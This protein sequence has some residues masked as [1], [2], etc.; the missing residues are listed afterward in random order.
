MTRV[1]VQPDGITY[2]ANIGE[3]LM[4]AA[5][6]RGLYWPTTCGGQG[7]CTTC[8]SEVVS[9]GEALNDMGR[10]E[11]KTLVNER[12]EA[13]LKR[14]VRLAC[15]QISERHPFLPLRPLRPRVSLSFPSGSVARLLRSL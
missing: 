15:R 10:S 14:P 11:R 12:G 7:V 5:Q 13:V 9:G 1:T 6:A 8:L 4:G 2:E 3:T